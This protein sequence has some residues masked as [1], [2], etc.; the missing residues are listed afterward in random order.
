MT[1]AIETRGVHH[2]ALRS[3]D[4]ARSRQFYV[5]TLGFPIA[6]EGP[7]IFL[8]LAGQT[9]FAVRGPEAA[10]P[11]GDAF[12]PF[13]VGL[14]HVALACA[15]EAELG[16]VASALA[17]ASVENTGVKLDPTLNRQY[18]A[19]KDPDRIAWEM[20]M[21][22]DVNVQAVQAYFEGLRHRNVD[23]IPFAPDASFES[24]LTPRISGA[25]AIRDFL[26]TALPVIRDVRV[27]QYMSHGDCV[28]A[29]FDLDTTYGLIPGFDWFRV[30]DGLIVEAR[31]YFDPQPLTV[32]A[33][34]A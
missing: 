34:A 6:L 30:V 18:V 20:Y 4:L 27:S 21:A 32:K 26:R 12:N 11:A 25:S 3:T 24:P 15:D 33:G 9:A 10:T 17:A 31:P 23:A 5:D 13:R 22:P 2:L 8:F 28:A 14:D 19:F 29:R 7:N 16:R 1:I